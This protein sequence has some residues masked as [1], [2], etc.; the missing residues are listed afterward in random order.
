[1]SVTVHLRFNFSG[2][3]NLPYILCYVTTISSDYAVIYFTA[4]MLSC[5]TA[6]VLFSVI[7]SRFDALL[8]YFIYLAIVLCF[9][10][11]AS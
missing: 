2:V 1:M 10:T 9:A 6:D 3:L 8:F 5:D 4:S 11:V 7:S